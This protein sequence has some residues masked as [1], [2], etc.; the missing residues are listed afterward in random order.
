MKIEI[1]NTTE[2]ILETLE[3][4]GFSAY[5]VG[6]SL[7][8][9]LLNIP[10][11]DIDIATNATPGQVRQIFEEYTVVDTGLKH[12]TVTLII[13][14]IP[15]EITTFRTEGV[16]SDNRRPDTVFFSDFIEDDLKRRDFTVNALAYSP[17]SGL[18]DLFGGISDLENKILRAVG[19]PEKR[20]S[21]DALRIIRG[22]RFASVLSFE[23]EPITKSAMLEYS[24]LL[25][26][27]AV[28]R[29]YNELIRMLGGKK[30]DLI[31]REFLYI[32]N[33]IIPKITLPEKDITTLTSPV[34][35]LATLF[36]NA[37]DAGIAL[38]SLKADSAT[39][40]QVITLLNSSPIPEDRVQIKR[41]LSKISLTALDIALF[42]Q[43]FFGETGAY[44]RIKDIMNSGECYS[45]G[46]L[47]INGIDIV[48]LG[49]SGS[50][51]GKI[52]KILLDMVIEGTLENT[53]DTLLKAV[54]N[55]D[56]R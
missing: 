34:F 17:K 29:I 43:Q 32:F 38:R 15:Y 5:V 12:G 6:G 25:K 24:E 35:R 37:E 21:E 1:D 3:N 28:E 52:L 47:A 44:E 18:I 23:I 22:L 33:M 31:L 53:K 8:D 9:I 49:F 40:K 20:F 27:I 10:T 42:R 11:H 50:E 41:F 2:F 30:F 13:D 48:N 19:E 55:I 56:N 54:I 39:I 51:V 46:H 16:Y 36:K 7:R 45:L 4:N 14:H 26:N